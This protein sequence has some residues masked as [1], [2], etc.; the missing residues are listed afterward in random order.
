MGEKFNLAQK[1]MKLDGDI[2]PVMHII[3][4]IPK[5]W[6]KIINQSRVIEVWSR[7]MLKAAHAYKLNYRIIRNIKQ[8]FLYVHI[9]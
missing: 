2:P 3:S 4:C 7:V 9:L 6:P 5:V 1:Y 8:Q